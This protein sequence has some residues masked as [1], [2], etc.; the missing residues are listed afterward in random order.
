MSLQLGAAA[1]LALA[2]AALLWLPREEAAD[3]RRQRLVARHGIEIGL[4]APKTFFV[5]PYSERDLPPS[6]VAD[7]VDPASAAIA[8]EG[9]ERAL[10]PYPR[11][12]VSGL[13][14]AIFVAGELRVGGAKAGGTVGPAWLILAAPARL[15][16]EGIFA[17]AYIGVHHELSSF[18]LQREPATLSEW[19]RFAP[20]NSLADPQAIIAR[21]AGADPDPE[22]GFL[23]AYGATNAENDFNVYAEKIFTEPATV[24]RLARSHA[25]V[26]KKLRFVVS[27]YLRIDARMRGVFAELGVTE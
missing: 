25:L 23:S 11:G 15:G 4:G 9:I 19:Q 7:Q 14:K 8:L 27:S 5:P 16:R 18:V 12:F 20:E 17:T 21:G 6:V 22:T 10:E 1:V 3:A 24:Q 2:G 26:R 13:I